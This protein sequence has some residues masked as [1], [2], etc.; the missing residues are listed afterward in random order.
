VRSGPPPFI[1]RPLI[2]L[3]CLVGG[4][5]SIAVFVAPVP[6]FA[7]AS[8]V[9]AT[10]GTIKAFGPER[11]NVSIAHEAI[12]G[13]MVAM[14][15]NFEPRAAEQ[16]AGLA[17]GDEVDFSFEAA[18]EGRWRLVTIRRRAAGPG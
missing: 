18:A 15:M 6:A 9:H 10:R 16:L 17:V 14:T 11:A 13:F 12:P 7:D 5:G 3:A 8:K 2:A 4:A 1:R